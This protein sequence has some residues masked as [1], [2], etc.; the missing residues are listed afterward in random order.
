MKRTVSP[1]E[2]E[3][4]IETE[5][6]RARRTPLP[7]SA[8]RELLQASPSQRSTGTRTATLTPTPSDIVPPKRGSLLAVGR[9]TR[10][11]RLNGADEN[12]QPVA[13]SSKHTLS[14]GQSGHSSAPPRSA[15]SRAVIHIDDE[16][17]GDEDSEIVTQRKEE[18][19]FRNSKPTHG[20]PGR[21]KII[22]IDSDDD[23]LDIQLFFS[24]SPN[25]IPP[26]RKR[27]I[28]KRKGAP[29]VELPYKPLPHLKSFTLPTGR[30]GPSPLSR[31][32]QIQYRQTPPRSPHASSEASAATWRVDRPERSGKF[33]RWATMPKDADQ[34]SSD[35]GGYGEEVISDDEIEWSDGESSDGIEITRRTTRRNGKGKEKEMRRTTRSEAIVSNGE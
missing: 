2:E 12:Q 30:K 28:R 19:N 22:N 29:Y 17:D 24:S 26:P 18:G 11:R 4:P 23:Q 8:F 1:E 16:S 33:P 21:E 31:N 20:H 15:R 25:P 27:I 10:P 5:A 9:S 13:S 3:E 14:V 6:E 32:E 7:S 35:L 34:S